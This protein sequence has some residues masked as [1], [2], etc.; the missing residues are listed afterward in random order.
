MARATQSR[1]HVQVLPDCLRQILRT[2]VH[3]TMQKCVMPSHM[4][5]AHFLLTVRTALS[6]SFEQF[7]QAGTRHIFSAF[8]SAHAGEGSKQ[9]RITWTHS[10]AAR[11][12]V[13]VCHESDAL[14][15][16]VG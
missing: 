15:I 9:D 7:C 6:T 2:S 16:M 4:F 12:L 11:D 8:V 1:W 13:S 3:G 5:C 14:N 10:R